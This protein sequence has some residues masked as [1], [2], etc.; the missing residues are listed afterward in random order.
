MAQARVVEKSVGRPTRS[1]RAP[2]RLPRLV[3]LLCCEHQPG[4]PSICGAPIREELPDSDAEC[5][6]CLDLDETDICPRYGRCRMGS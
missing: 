2:T 3:H 5:I 6:V 1:E 4:L